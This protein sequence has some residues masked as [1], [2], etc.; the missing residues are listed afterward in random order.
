MVMTMRNILSILFIIGFLFVPFQV[1]A[2]ANKQVIREFIDAVVKRDV[3]LARSYVRE[4]VIIP[5]IRE[6][7]PIR[8]V[9]GLPSPKQGV[10][11]AVGYFEDKLVERIGFIW[12]IQ[13]DNEKITEIRVVYDGSNPFMNEGSAVKEYENK[14]QK[15]ILVPS[16]FP[17]KVTHID[18]DV[19]GDV[20]LVRYRNAEIQGTVQIKVV[21]KEAELERLQGE[22]NQEY[23]LK[24]G[25]KAVYQEHFLPAYRLVFQKGDLQYYIGINRSIQQKVTADDLIEIANSMIE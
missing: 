4:G 2:A 8:N 17:F 24:T 10:R 13:T 22:Q 21:P 16:K 19:D 1:V 9:T 12:E 15:Q 18:A 5:E 3:T 14:Y 25:I 20:L 23:M 6:N 7:T 11:V